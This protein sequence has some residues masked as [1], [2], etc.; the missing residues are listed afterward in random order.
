ML[1]AMSRDVSVT[2]AR[3]G[4]SPGVAPNAVPVCAEPQGHRCAPPLR[5]RGGLEPGLA[6]Q[7]T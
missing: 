2:R 7:T 1:L 4:T 6:E 3:A 5:P